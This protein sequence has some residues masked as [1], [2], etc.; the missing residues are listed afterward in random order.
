MVFLRSQ[1]DGYAEQI[2]DPQKKVAFQQAISTMTFDTNGMCLGGALDF[3]I[4]TNL[5]SL[6]DDF[7]ARHI[8]FLTQAAF[9]QF[10]QT[11]NNDTGS[12]K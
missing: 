7:H 12:E 11:S 1:L 4:G 2:Q 6:R 8:Q 5:E 3:M 10:S 9:D